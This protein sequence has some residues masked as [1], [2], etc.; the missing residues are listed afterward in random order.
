M[1]EI[2]KR[3]LDTKESTKF[4]KNK[5]NLWLNQVLEACVKLEKRLIELKFNKL[6]ADAETWYRLENEVN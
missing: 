1:S 2:L 4:R 6:K 3:Q 5:Y